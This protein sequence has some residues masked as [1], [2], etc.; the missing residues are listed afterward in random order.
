MTNADATQ[1]KSAVFLD[2]SSFMG[3]RRKMAKK[4]R[5]TTRGP[6]QPGQPEPKKKRI[7]LNNARLRALAQRH[8]PPQSWYDEEQ[9][10]LYA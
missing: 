10:G 8:K 9:E 3:T 4:T 5:V 6:E 2:I 7:P 1:L